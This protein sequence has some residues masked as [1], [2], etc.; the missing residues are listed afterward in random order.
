MSRTDLPPQPSTP[1]L[2]SHEQVLALGAGKIK[3]QHRN[4]LALVYVRQSTQQ[5]VLNNRESADRQYALKERAV[6]LGWPADRVVIVDDDQARSGRS[7][8]Q[9]GGFTF[10]L[11]QIASDQV[12]ILLGLEMSRLT[13]SCKDWHHLLES[14][15]IFDTLLADQDGVYDPG[16]A[17]D[18]LLL[19]LKGA[20]SEAELHVLRG[21]LYE[22]LLNKARRGE[23]FNHPPIGYV[24]SPQGDFDLDPDAQVQAAVRLVFEQFD[25]QGTV[26]GVLRYL[27]QHRLRVPVRP[28]TG[29]QRGQ[30]QWHRPNRPTL[31]GILT[32]PIYAGF[33][34]WGHRTTDPRRRHADRPRSGRVTRPLSECLVL[35][36]GRCPAYISVEQFRANQDRLAA[37][38]SSQQ[39]PGAVRR[40]PALLGGLLVCA[41]CG[42][43]LMVNY[44]DGGRNLRY[45]C[46]RALTSYGEPECQSL[47]GRR[48]DHFVGEQVLAALQPAALEL[49]LA[50]AA[51]IEQQRQALHQQW[52][53]RLQRARYQA[54]LAARQYQHVDPANRLVAGELERRWEAALQE[55]QSL[56]GEYQRFS[57]R[58]PARLSAA[59]QEQIHALAEDIPQLWQ[60]D[61]TTAAD[62]KRVVRLLVERVE[63]GVQGQSEQ[64]EVAIHWA[65]G[66]VSRHRLV[67]SVQRYEQLAD[68]QRLCARMDELRAA[69]K[70]MAEVAHCLNEEGYHPPRRAERFSGGMV[71]GFLA[72]RHRAAGEQ[73]TQ[74]VAPI[75]DKEEW[76]LGDL[77][78][79]LGMP[80]ATLHRWRKAGWVRARKLAVAGG[81][82]ALWASGA[83][84][85]RLGRLRR[86]QQG[87]P[88]QAPPAD[89]TT[90]ELPKEQ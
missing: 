37:N 25:R 66:C 18:R 22:N 84:R 4:R 49:H 10:V 85:H 73:R 14:C 82:W 26:Y 57:A 24:K 9:R 54:D 34:R 36:P 50:A 42:C 52:Q 30:L 67:R 83:E 90:P 88:N 75:L 61:T 71:A 87:K 51:D 13:R 68:Y 21:R 40:G 15:A 65:G 38:R 6:L 7:A 41:R 31:H 70:S 62:R 5:Q 79:H 44:T 77:A 47:S 63:V 80:P 76:L 46:A 11:G 45:C 43:R 32:H 27:V 56:Q 35:L 78:R 86:H 55:L 81:P 8:Q 33:Y 2:P 1:P 53:Q 48:L 19:G 23:V 17:N 12:G 74:E 69:G 89:L 39:T 72:R 16:N 60:A 3:P 20:M 28:L 59:E 58:Q 29:E 64:V